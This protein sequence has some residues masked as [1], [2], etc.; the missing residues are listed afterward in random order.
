MPQCGIL[1]LMVNQCIKYHKDVLCARG[2][3]KVLRTTYYTGTN[4]RKRF[5][6]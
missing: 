5:T 4:L 1:I 2:Q 6:R 3:G